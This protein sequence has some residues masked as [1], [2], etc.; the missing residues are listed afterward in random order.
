MKFL[1]IVIIYI[2]L[3]SCDSNDEPFKDDLIGIWEVVD[4]CY[5]DCLEGCV[6]Y[7][8]PENEQEYYKLDENGYMERYIYY[9][10]KS[11]DE[12][13]FLE[14]YWTLHGEAIQFCESNSCLSGIISFSEDKQTLI[15][16]AS[17][18]EQREE[19]I[20]SGDFD[21]E[22]SRYLELERVNNNP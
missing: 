9:H 14:K 17:G 20:G 1:S 6:E 4:D 7:E 21:C 19:T 16:N 11:G 2:L 10:D 13:D 3:L 15:I 5:T 18:I 22:W 12:I 8:P